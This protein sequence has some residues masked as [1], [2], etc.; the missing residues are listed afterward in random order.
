VALRPLV[1]DVADPRAEKVVEFPYG[2]DEL[3]HASSFVRVVVNA[4]PLQKGWRVGA[5]VVVVV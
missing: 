4:T 5:D 2:T 1:D 3:R